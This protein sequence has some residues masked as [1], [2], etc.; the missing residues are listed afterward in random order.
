MPVK[1]LVAVW[2][3]VAAGVSNA[4]ADADKPLL[5]QPT[6]SGTSVVFMYADDLWTVGR[7]GGDARRLTTHPGYEWNPYFSPD[8]SSVAFT[9][10]YDGNSDVFIIPAT[11][12]EPKRLTY[13]PGG[14][15]VVGWT[16]D[17]KNIAFSSSRNSYSGFERLFTVP[18]EGGFPSEIPLPI[19]LQGSFSPDG[20]R[21]AYVPLPG[22]F[23][24]WK[25][26]RGGMASPIWIADLS[27][28]RIE[29]L[30]R[31]DWNDFNPMWVGD[32]IY[33]LSD[34]DG[35]VTL[36]EHHIR[37]GTAKELIRN[38]GLD[39]KWASAGPGA[40]VYEQFGSLF[41]YDL[42]S[43]R[44]RPIE[45]RVAADL[46][47]V[48]PHFSKVS[49]KIEWAGLSP[50][51][52]RAIF[53]ARGEI[54]TVPVEKGDIRNLTRT[55]GVSER[56]PAWSPDGKWIAYFSDESGEYALHLR[57]QS[58]QGEIR[59]IDL[60]NP[61]SFFYRPVWSPDSKKIAYTDKRLNIWYVDL[62]K[63]KPVL[64]DTDTYLSS[65]RE[66]SPVW[67]P[68]SR[69]IAYTKQLKSYMHALFVHGLDNGKTHKVTDGLSDAL[70]PGFDDGGK[71]L[72]F[73][74]STDLGP[75][76]SELEMSTINRPVTRSVY[77]V[78]LDKD[79]P[80]PLA[81]ESDEEGEEEE[82]EK[83]DE[84]DDKD[85]TDSE[86]DAEDE[87]EEEEDVTVE[88]DFE[89][90]D[91]RI[92]AL[93]IPAKNYVSLEVGKDSTLFLLE[94]WQLPMSSQEEELRLH[95]FDLETRK[96]EKILE[97]SGFFTLSHDGEKLLYEQKKSWFVVDAGEPPEPGK[98]ALNLEPM[99]VRIDP[100]AEWRQMYDEVWRIERDFLYDPGAHGFDL[101]A[102]QKRYEPFVDG[103]SSRDDLNYLFSE[104]LGNL[105]LGHVFVFG[106]DTPDIKRV[107]GG[108]L[109]A[110]FVIEDGRYRFARVYHG[111]NWN[112]KLQA[113]LTQPGVNVKAG[114]YLLEVDGR[115]VT[116]A[117]NVYS[118]FENT[119]KKQVLLK[120]GPA[121][122]GTD[123]RDVTVVPVPSE[124]ALRHRAWIDGNRRK[125]DTMSNGQVGYVYLPDTAG[126][127]YTNF[128]RY[129]FAQ[130]GKQGLVVDERF[131]SGGLAADYIVDNMRRPLANYWT[132]R[133]GEDFT[134]PKATVQGPKVMIIN[135]FAGSGGDWM[136][137]YFRRTGVGKLIGKRTWG[138][139]V[140]IGGT[141]GL[142]DGGW[143][144]APHFAFWNPEGSWE[145]ENYGVDPDIEVEFDPHAWR[146]GGDPQ[147]EKAVETVLEELRRNPPPVHQKPA[148]PD[149]H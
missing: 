37:T 72:Y 149:Y 81:P 14:D 130:A 64:V 142:I 69:W 36:F 1:K 139:L 39:I 43:A 48:R 101:K 135:E 6:I 10:T 119:A 78:V 22:A 9:G 107:P 47:L 33:F 57:D 127:G 65:P 55:P 105:V 112:P 24:I 87:E 125:V 132:P 16:P 13:H 8:G 34:R 44:S 50:S 124:M 123:A 27:D 136:P 94:G 138:G 54:L 51:G 70:F 12:G 134:T 141:P 114:D 126:G 5:R 17:G 91:Q 15:V 66:L 109:G 104:M 128:N 35:S 115:D 32:S 95:K 106:G 93:P 40:I 20:S 77:V 88:I 25:R 121:P 38:E 61:P 122:D 103:L 100:R 21:I 137:W 96:T 117:D 92:L 80:S 82:D 131:N 49:E 19:A 118:F 41:L 148:Y 74:A 2:L 31:E 120:V 60:G 52:K 73:T 144:S 11:G 67:S 4:G 59:K 98:G 86:K 29:K 143:V 56:S 99:E 18:V 113:P 23:Q 116:G 26:Y 89:D 102:A 45:I 7:E 79:E 83:K 145:V 111:E 46:P 140:G 110:D 53:Q 68:D 90:I 71:Y 58:G 84:K 85:A 133:D 42:E 97:G 108:L 62:E 63:E 28:S 147:L 146:Q 129:Y 3:F 76:T 75:G 30:Q